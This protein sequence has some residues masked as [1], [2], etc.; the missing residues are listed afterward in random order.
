MSDPNRQRRAD[1]VDET[2]EESFPASDL[3]GCAGMH[4]VGT[5]RWFA[6]DTPSLLVR[7][8]ALDEA[9]ARKLASVGAVLEGAL[10]L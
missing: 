6:Y 8:R 2:A 7:G 10:R 5:M 1:S 9:L 4:T 3:P